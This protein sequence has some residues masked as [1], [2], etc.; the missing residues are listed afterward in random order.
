MRVT[1]IIPARYE[2]TRFKGKAT[3]LIAGKPMIQH[4]Y[5]RAARSPLVDRV[6]LAT[7]DERILRAAG[8]F[9][10]EAIMTSS[11]LRCG[12]DRVAEAADRLGLSEEDL[13]VNIQGDQPCFNP[14]QIAQVSAPLVTEPDLPMSTLVYRITDPSEI[15]DPNIVKTVFD[16]RGRALYF[17]RATIPH[18]RGGMGE[19]PYYKHHGIYGYRRHFL[20]TF[21]EWPTSAMEEAEKLEQ[22]RALDYGAPIQVV[23]TE[24]DSLEVDTPKDVAKVE[25]LMRMETPV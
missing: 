24:F 5:E 17:S 14:V 16:R 6:V 2:S 1:V 23:I 20:R 11:S 9:G 4:V 25:E 13:V 8:E 12:T 22:L 21:A 10:G 15:D 7:D 3:A 18:V 19:I